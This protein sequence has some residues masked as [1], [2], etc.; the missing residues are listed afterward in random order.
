VVSATTGPLGGM[1]AAMNMQ[2]L[3]LGVSGFALPQ[4][5]LVGNLPQRFDEAGNL[6]DPAFEKSINNFL[7]NF[8]WLAEA[9]VAKKE[10]VGV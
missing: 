10:T 9:V 2:E 1:R 5:L 6:I 8:L 4:M 7:N 3:V